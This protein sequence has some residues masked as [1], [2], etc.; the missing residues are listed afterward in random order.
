MTVGKKIKIINSKIK[1]KQ[2]KASYNLDKQTSN[3]SDLLSGD[4]CK[5][6]FLT[7]EDVLP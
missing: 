7:N 5:Y 2:N 4:V 6:R 3:I 1:T